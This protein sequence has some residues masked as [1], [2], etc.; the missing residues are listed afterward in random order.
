MRPLRSLP[1]AVPAVTVAVEESEDQARRDPDPAPEH[2]EEQ[3]DPVGEDVGEKATHLGNSPE[4]VCNLHFEG[5]NLLFMDGH[6]KWRAYRKLRSGG[7]G[8]IPDEPWSMTNSH[9]PDG[10]GVCMPDL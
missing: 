9:Y 4:Y 8:L 2:V 7:F 3:A 5:A 1:R 10:C 6:I